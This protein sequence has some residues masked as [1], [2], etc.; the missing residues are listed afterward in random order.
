M[1]DGYGSFAAVYD[2]LN[3]DFPYGE[4]A[5]YYDALIKKYTAPGNILLD[6]GCGSGRL[7]F[8]MEQKGYDV[9]GID[10]SEEMLSM[11]LEGKMES[12]SD[13]LFLC[14]RMEELDMFGTMDV[15]VSC[16]DCINH[17]ENIAAVKQTFEKVHLFGAPDGLFIF[18]CN[19][20]YKH[21]KVLAGETFVYDTEDVYCVW[22]N[23]LLDGNV[24]QMDL[25]MFFALEE[26]GIY[27]RMCESFCEKAYEKE[28]IESLLKE[29]GFELL[30]IFDGFTF[31]A[32][33]ADSQRLVFAARIKKEGTV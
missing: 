29:T 26:E 10:A 1:S 4:V 19:T 23:T 17:L 31:D 22:Q 28:E 15:T 16:L 32:P 21:Q 9:V 24:V 33:K 3:R 14:Q 7:S 6:L 8:L 13:A 30:G 25:D 12:G 27:E 18:D 11:A 20:V 2:E 5:D